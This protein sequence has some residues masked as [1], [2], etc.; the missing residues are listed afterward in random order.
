MSLLD[1]STSPSLIMPMLPF[2]LT[3]EYPFVDL[4]E[5]HL[6]EF[7]SF[8]LDADTYIKRYYIG[9]YNPSGNFFLACAIK[10][11]IGEWLDPKPKPYR[12]QAGID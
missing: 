7:K 8:N 5:W 9:H 11:K 1:R 4:R 6:A 10:D 2:R 3:Q 12:S